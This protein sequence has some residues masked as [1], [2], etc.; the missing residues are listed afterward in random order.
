MYLWSTCRHPD[1]PPY[2]CSG[3]RCFRKCRPKRFLHLIIVSGPTKSAGLG[4]TGFGYRAFPH[5]N[6]PWYIALFICCNKAAFVGGIASICLSFCVHSCSLAWSTLSTLPFL[7]YIVT[8]NLC[9]IGMNTWNWGGAGF[10][11]IAKASH[12][13]SFLL[14]LIQEER[15][16]VTAKDYARSTG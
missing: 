12:I 3:L 13:L 2:I 6:E 7:S 14:R 1:N 9:K 11:I 4:S 15:L 8:T 16:S 5:T 10:I